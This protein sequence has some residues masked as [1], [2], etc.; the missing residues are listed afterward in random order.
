MSEY[1]PEEILPPNKSEAEIVRSI[2]TAMV[3]A[4]IR[5]LGECEARQ[6]SGEDVSK[7]DVV[8]AVYAAMTR[9]K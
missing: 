1:V 4:G 6:E 5:A 9:L 7:S 8:C 3:F 2:T